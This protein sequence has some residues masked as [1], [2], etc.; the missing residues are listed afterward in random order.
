MLDFLIG[1]GLK[2]SRISSWPDYYDEAPGSSVPGR[3]VVAD[4]FDANELGEAKALLRPNFL[5]LPVPLEDA[6]KLPHV[7]KS[8]P[9]KVALIKMGLRA[10]GAKLTGKNYVTAGAAL[11]GRMM[12]GAIKAGADLRVNSPVKELIEQDGRIVGE[13]RPHPIQAQK[14]RPRTPCQARP[15][16]PCAAVESQPTAHSQQPP[17]PPITPPPDLLTGPCGIAGR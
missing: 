16:T 12:Q 2:F 4:L 6:L 15:E 9:A 7:K 17:M 11:Q 3:T 5:T 1:K 8:W 13:A 14:D 10:L